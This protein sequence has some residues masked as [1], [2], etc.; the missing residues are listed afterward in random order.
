[1]NKHRSYLGL[2]LGNAGLV[3]VGLA[4][5]YTMA[6]DVVTVGRPLIGEL[7]PMQFIKWLSWGCYLDQNINIAVT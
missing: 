2:G 1:M 5:V 4:F 7:E 3:E 6:P